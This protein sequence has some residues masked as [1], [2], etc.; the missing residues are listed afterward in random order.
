MSED[1]SNSRHVRFGSDAVDGEDEAPGGGGERSPARRTAGAAVLR[2]G[3]NWGGGG[4][5]AV[6]A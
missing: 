1:K 2:G 6:R 4:G 5:I 3:V